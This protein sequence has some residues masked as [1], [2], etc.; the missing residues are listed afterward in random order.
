MLGRHT[1]G[2]D[3]AGLFLHGT[4]LPLG[5]LGELPLHRIIQASDNDGCHRSHLPQVISNRLQEA[6]RK[7]GMSET[8]REP[9]HRIRRPRLSSL[10]DEPASARHPES[11]ADDAVE[12]PVGKHTSRRDERFCHETDCVTGPG[13]AGSDDPLDGIRD[14]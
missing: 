5:L 9:H 12:D 13:L 2:R 6:R 11:R 7:A 4:S 8:S 10:L 1:L 14:D 3:V